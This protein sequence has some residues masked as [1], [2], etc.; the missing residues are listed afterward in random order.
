MI[1][2]IVGSDGAPFWINGANTVTRAIR[3]GVWWDPELIP[4]FAQFCRST[5]WTV[6]VGAYIGDHSI[7]L[8]QHGPL[9]AIEPQAIAWAL[10]GLNLAL[11]PARYPWITLRT[12]LYSRPVGLALA[13]AWGAPDDPSSAYEIAATGP[14]LTST[15]DA[16]DLPRPVGLLKIDAQG[17]DLHVLR[18]GE[19]LITEDRPVILCEFYKDLAVLHG[20]SVESHVAWFADH[21]YELRDL[22]GD[23]Y[24]GVPLL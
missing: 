11:R 9:V 2:Q 15:L 18:G 12:A 5:R 13:A 8:M 1:E 24:L 23:N 10:L 4:L 16:L 20:D 19:R 17:C 6:E 7:A 14:L 21:R 22:G 3:P